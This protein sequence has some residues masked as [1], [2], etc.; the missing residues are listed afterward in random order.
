MNYNICRPS[1]PL[2]FLVSV[3]SR[4]PAD[5]P[6]FHHRSDDD[7][8]GSRKVES[9][10]LLLFSSFPLPDYLFNVGNREFVGPE[11]D[12]RVSLKLPFSVRLGVW[13]G[14]GGGDQPARKIFAGLVDP[15]VESHPPNNPLLPFSA[16]M[17]HSALLD[18]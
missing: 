17:C 9:H 10:S 14:G 11:V 5:P 13:S 16:L 12:H 7:T 3:S 2:P 15:F 6:L 8:S 1:S 4:L 18:N